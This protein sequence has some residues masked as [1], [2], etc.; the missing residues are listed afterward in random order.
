[1]WLYVV[2]WV[3]DVY[4]WVSVGVWLSL[5]VHICVYMWKH[6]CRFVCMSPQLHVLILGSIIS[7]SQLIITTRYAAILVRLSL[8]YV[9]WSI[10]NLKNV[11]MFHSRW[12]SP[13]V[14][15]YRDNHKDYEDSDTDPCHRA[16]CAG[17]P[18]ISNHSK[19]Q[20]SFCFTYICCPSRGNCLVV[21]I[22]KTK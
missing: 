22:I 6:M 17:R 3:C 1:M 13:S 5:C 2:Q 9:L 19:C 7:W 11:L 21:F 10:I 20:L 14:N 15:E 18:C 16:G 4:V 12:C 8:I